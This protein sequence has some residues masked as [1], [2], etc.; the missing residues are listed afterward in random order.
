VNAAAAI[1][2]AGYCAYQAFRQVFF[3][4]AEIADAMAFLERKFGRGPTD[5]EVAEQAVA[6]SLWLHAGCAVLVCVAV[7]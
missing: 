4:E 6:F 7:W 2:F 1:V 5:T 3:R